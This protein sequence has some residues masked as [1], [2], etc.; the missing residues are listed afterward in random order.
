MGDPLKKFVRENRDAFDDLVPSDAV[1]QRLKKQ[2]N[3]QPVIKRGFFARL[4]PRTWG[5][6]ASL[7][8]ALVLTYIFYRPG[9]TPLPQ[10]IAWTPQSAPSGVTDTPRATSTPTEATEETTPVEHVATP[11]KP[12]A[13]KHPAKA[14]EVSPHW[15]WHTQLAD[16]NS[17]S[18][19]LAA[20]LE[21]DRTAKL[22]DELVGLLADAMNHDANSN[23][24]MAALDAL[25]RRAQDPY[26]TELFITSLTTQN[27]PFVQLGLI[28]F[29][30]QVD[31][32]M[33]DQTLYALADDPNTFTVVKDEAY[34]TL[35]YQN[36]L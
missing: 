28:H 26:I 29:L 35:L 8:L 15:A 27:D 34:A 1:L 20:I 13:R 22:D 10:D 25:G 32:E 31:N 30:K 6:A 16:S 23:V 33:V 7:I 36:K 11:T 14:V 5:V 17:A 19:R 2:L 4:K 21:I 9:E 24:R 3:P 18:T 12:I